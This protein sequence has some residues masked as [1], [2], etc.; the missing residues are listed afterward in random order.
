MPKTRVRFSYLLLP[1]VEGVIHAS[2]FQATVDPLGLHP[3]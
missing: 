2:R 1:S 3:D